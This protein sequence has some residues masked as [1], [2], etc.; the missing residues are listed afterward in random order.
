MV[1][2]RLHRTTAKRIA[3]TAAGI[4]VGVAGVTTGLQ[5]DHTEEQAVAPVAE[6]AAVVG[7]FAYQR[8]ANPARTVVTDSTRRVVA[9]LTDGARAANVLGP[10]RTFAE[11]STTSHSVSSQTWV[12]ILPSPWLPG[13]EREPWFPAWLDAALHDRQPDVLEVAT[14]YLRASPEH[15]DALGNRYR[16]DARFGSFDTNA[17][18]RVERSDFYD[19]LG[20]PWTFP[21]GRVEQPDPALIGTVDDSGFIR[22]VFGYRSG[23][24]LRRAGD[25]DTANSIPRGTNAIASEAPGTVIV[26][27]RQLPV[28]DFG[29]LQPGDLVFF[30]TDPDRR[31]DVVGI[32]LGI[33]DADHHRFIASRSAGDGP[34]MGDA[35]GAAVLDGGGDYSAAFRSAKRL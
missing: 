17:D 19:Y 32:Y 4:L 22:L 18:G 13:T 28:S 1:I 26:P 21:G 24:P 3:F 11:P 2:R 27:D 10:T 7:E 8:L 15:I 6:T 16:G 20:K 34:T 12:R 23:I 29:R 5:R 9:T 30:D 33:D 31:V 25:D 35:G 14:Q